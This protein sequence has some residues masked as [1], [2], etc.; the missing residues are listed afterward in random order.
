MWGGIV[1]SLDKALNIC[2][3]KYM[4]NKKITIYVEDQDNQLSEMIKRIKELS[5]PGH[6]FGVRMDRETKDDKFYFDG[7]GWFRIVKIEEEKI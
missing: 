2:D 1:K 5:D 6:S 3:K 4:G 7:D